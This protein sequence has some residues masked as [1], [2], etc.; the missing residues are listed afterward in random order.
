MKKF[1]LAAAVVSTAF[2]VSCSGV[3]KNNP[4]SVLMAFFDALG[5]KDFSAAR[6]LATKESATML[7]FMETMMKSAPK[8]SKD[9]EKYDKSK[10]EFGDPVINGDKA[11]ITV[12]EKGSARSEDYKLKK[13]S[14]GWKVAFEK[15]QN[16]GGMEPTTTPTIDT[17]HH[18]IM[19]DTTKHE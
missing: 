19:E 15:E 16:D 12:K 13:E 11:T 2:L 3:D 5:K 17:E 4:K 10:M 7:S 6:K 8:E 18:D 9:M 1:L 14:D